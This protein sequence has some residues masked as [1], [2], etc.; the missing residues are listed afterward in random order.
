MVAIFA[1][2]L[3]VAE[4]LPMRLV[5]D[6][7][8]GE[9]TMSST[10]ALA[11]LVVGGASAA[12]CAIAIGAL[13][14]D[15]LRHKP[16]QRMAF[17]IGQYVL[18]VAAGAAVLSALSGTSF[19]APHDLV[20][21]LLPAFAA[22]AVVFFF[23]NSMLVARAVTLA[24][25]AAF[26]GYLRR[27]IALQTSTVGI[28]LGL[29][30]IVVITADFSLCRAAAARAAAVRRLR[31]RPPGDHQPAPGAARRADAAP[32]PPRCSRSASTR[33]CGSRAVTTR[34]SR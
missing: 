33:R 9:I 18:S 10:F 22:A 5:H 17:N 27:D 25:G 14:S 20:P 34:A 13:C 16:A 2:A 4:C 19:W 3:I 32:Q 26:W 31:R 21:S 24:E 15:L 7:G 28:L 6:A 1:A 12:M 23:V 30:P 11:L 29:A 8:E